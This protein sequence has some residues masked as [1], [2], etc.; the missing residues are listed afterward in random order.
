M[1]YNIIH[2]NLNIIDNLYKYSELYY[3]SI[4]FGII[5]YLYK[6]KSNLKKTYRNNNSVDYWNIKKV[7]KVIEKQNEQMTIDDVENS[8]LIK[9]INIHK[10]KN[11]SF[12]FN[13]FIRKVLHKKQSLRCSLQRFAEYK[14]Y[15]T[16]KLFSESNLSREDEDYGHFI[17][18]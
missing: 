8:R 10:K 2:N 17:Y 16:K 1:L 4:W 6:L 12:K 11:I 15:N 9:K 3:I 18:L 7:S 13:Y 5:L 14:S